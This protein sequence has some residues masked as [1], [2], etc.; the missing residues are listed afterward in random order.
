MVCLL[1]F[2]VSSLSAQ[3]FQLEK[4]QARTGKTEVIQSLLLDDGRVVSLKSKGS[5]L[6]EATGRKL[7][8]ELLDHNLRLVNS[9]ETDIKYFSFWT[10]VQQNQFQFAE[11]LDGRV[12]IFY[13]NQKTVKEFSLYARELDVDKMRLSREE[14]KI[15]DFNKR[16][17]KDLGTIDYALSQDRSKVLVYFSE[18][19]K[20]NRKRNTYTELVMMDNELNVLWNTEYLDDKE[21]KY[22]EYKSYEVNNEGEVFVLKKTFDS[23]RRKVLGNEINYSFSLIKF[24][25]AGAFVLEKGLEL[26]N[27]HV[28]DIQ[29]K[30]NDQD[31]L[32]CAG[33][34]SERDGNNADGIYFAK[35]QS[36]N[37]TSKITKIEPFS[38]EFIADGKSRWVERRSARRDRKGKRVE[39]ENLKVRDFVLRSDGGVLLIGEEYEVKEWDEGEREYTE[40]QEYKYYDIMV[41]NINSQ[42]SIDWAKKIY[43]RQEL[44][45]E[46]RQ[47]TDGAFF[48]A[49]KTIDNVVG[50]ARDGF[51]SYTH[52][53]VGDKIYFIYN[54]HRENFDG[55]PGGDYLLAPDDIYSICAISSIDI[56]GEITKE[57]LFRS[58]DVDVVIYPKNSVQLNSAEPKLLLFGRWKSTERY[59]RLTF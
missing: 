53:V 52:C 35:F 13:A 42:G 22:K 59:M 24:D 34:Y 33:F 10:T 51:L 49:M 21:E 46:E 30:H 20:L 38:V 43:K 58:E 56:N 3:R 41:I 11:I 4:G 26:P 6:A 14:I 2:A 55:R 18:Y 9:T 29:I 7:E 28:K 36:D 31:E 1:L 40:F 17:R 57:A 47:D 45:L 15:A 39:L 23:N 32:I 50:M 27:N 12:F 25:A 8:I 48:T 37:L 19:V 16:D 54:D 44:M 5:L